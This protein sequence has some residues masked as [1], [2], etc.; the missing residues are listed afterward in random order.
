M[1]ACGDRRSGLRGNFQVKRR[2]LKQE[3]NTECG[4]STFGEVSDNGRKKYAKWRHVESISDRPGICWWHDK[5]CPR[6]VRISPTRRILWYLTLH[7]GMSD[8]HDPALSYGRIFHWW[9]P[10]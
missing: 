7:L 3:P 10:S 9:S 8:R 5:P 1:Y 4:L 2:S 6:D